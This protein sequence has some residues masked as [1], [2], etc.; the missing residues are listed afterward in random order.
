MTIKNKA[1]IDF[2][3]GKSIHKLLK[4][5]EFSDS[6]IKVINTA[7]LT[8]RKEKPNMSVIEKADNILKEVAKNQKPIISEAKVEQNPEV[9]AKIELMKSK[10]LVKTAKKEYLNLSNKKLMAFDGKLQLVIAIVMLMSIVIYKITNPKQEDIYA[11]LYTYQ[12]AKKLCSSQNKLLPL[13]IDD[14]PNKLTHPDKKNSIGYWSADKE[15]LFNIMLGYGMKD[16][17]KKHY[18]TCVDVNGKDNS[19]RF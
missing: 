11:K 5:F 12:E 9:L 14:A 6:E 4:K 19:I 1:V 13:T 10:N 3:R 16:D 2:Y 17:G 8:S 15:I 7:I 18:V